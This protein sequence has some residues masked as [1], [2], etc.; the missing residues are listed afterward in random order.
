MAYK[1][2]GHFIEACDCYVVCPCW[3][4]D[5]PDDGHCTGLFAWLL[6]DGSR[7]GGLDVGGRR[8]V[9]VTTH[10][11]NRRTARSDTVIFVDEQAGPEQA[12]RLAEVFAGQAEGPLA[13]LAAVS[14]Q[15]VARQQARIEIDP[16][17]DGDRSGWTITV[18]ALP[19]PL[20]PDAPRPVYV[21]ST[22]VP[23][24]FD[25]GPPMTLTHHAL[26]K[27]LGGAGGEPVTSQLGD[28]LDI[29]VGA[30]EG[31][32]VE[33]TGRSGMRGRFSYQHPAPGEPDGIGDATGTGR[34]R[35][36]RPG[37]TGRVRR[38]SSGSTGKRP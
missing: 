28:R 37:R 12:A 8:V 7:V 31:G 21:Q 25:D 18:R 34:D 15:V 32:W 22:G 4:D 1:L 10:R 20:H 13:D 30:L 14:G 38:T 5:D 36:D 33:V 26:A 17:A 23:R 2:S 35:P 24:S 6:E 11:G 19:D 9:A 29:R 3:V 27:E 16:A